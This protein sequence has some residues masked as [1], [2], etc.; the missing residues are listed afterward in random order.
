MRL[1]TAYQRLR[2]PLEPE[3]EQARLLISRQ[4]D[5]ELDAAGARQLKAHLDACP[6]C[7]RTLEVQSEQAR[8]LAQSLAGLWPEAH[9]VKKKFAD[10]R[11]AWTLTRLGGPCGVAFA[12]ALTWSI[13]VESNS[14]A[15]QGKAV[16]EPPDGKRP[17][18]K[19][20]PPSSAHLPAVD[21]H[22]AP[23][24]SANK[25]SGETPGEDEDAGDLNEF[26]APTQLRAVPKPPDPPARLKDLLAE[27]RAASVQPKID[28]ELPRAIF[29]ARELTPATVAATE[30][31][32]QTFGEFDAQPAGAPLRGVAMAYSL[33]RNNGERE[34]GRVLLLGD[35]THNLG[36][37]RLETDGGER[38][39]SA[40]TK[41]ESAF[42][43]ERR[44]V[45]RNFLNM[46]ADPRFKAEL[47]TRCKP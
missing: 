13:L 28:S 1:D 47:E 16:S 21:V 35:V 26:E 46:C 23:D 4:I 17:V 41:W 27:D 22:A 33:I 24:F 29:C 45:V 37:L 8:E 10:G 2:E 6:V 43:P 3:C 40:Q 9:P 19:G 44:A 36:R 5:R 12:A 31:V 7:R 39:E 11:L 42:S 34:S 15:P 20:A 32:T 18:S 38:I 30:T 14:G 25:I